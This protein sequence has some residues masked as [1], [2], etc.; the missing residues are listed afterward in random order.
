MFEIKR[1][2]DIINKRFFFADIWLS[3]FYTGK[4]CINPYLFINI[5]LYYKIVLFWCGK[6]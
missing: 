5:R 6:K 4:I 3:S 1:V 2:R